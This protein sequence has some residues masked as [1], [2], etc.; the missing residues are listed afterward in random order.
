[1]KCQAL[2]PM[3]CPGETPGT[4]QL[5]WR[6]LASHHKYRYL[7]NMWILCRYPCVEVLVMTGEG[8]HPTADTGALLPVKGSTSGIT[9]LFSA[10]TSPPHP[11]LHLTLACTSPH[12]GL[13]TPD[14]WLHHAL[15]TACWCPDHFIP[16]QLLNIG[17]L[18]NIG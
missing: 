7:D 1:M 8:W 9:T 11:C 10:A 16:L 2:L 4:L 18:V 6:G 13:V 3:Q 5:G 15:Q 12:R 17:T 14:K